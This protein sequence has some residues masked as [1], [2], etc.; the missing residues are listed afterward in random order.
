M[1]ILYALNDVATLN[2][3]FLK[4]EIVIDDAISWHDL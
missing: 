2:S 1:K 4:G 3:R